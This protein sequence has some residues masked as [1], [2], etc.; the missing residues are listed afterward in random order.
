MRVTTGPRRGS[1]CAQP[2]WIVVLPHHAVPLNLSGLVSKNLTARRCLW[3]SARWQRCVASN[4]LACPTSSGV[5]ARRIFRTVVDSASLGAWHIRVTEM[6]RL[7]RP[8]PLPAS[9]ADRIA[10]GHNLGHPR[11]QLPVRRTVVW[12]ASAHCA[13][14]RRRPSRPSAK[15]RHHSA[16]CSAFAPSNRAATSNTPLTSSSSRSTTWNSRPRRCRSVLRPS[17]CQRPRGV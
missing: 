4:P 13:A 3:T 6:P 9:P 7:F 10:I 16:T 14:A 17:G 12:S 11:A 8:N 1:R 5:R 15:R 2:L